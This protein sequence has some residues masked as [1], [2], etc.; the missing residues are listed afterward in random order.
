[1]VQRPRDGR[2]GAY[3]GSVDRPGDPPGPFSPR[4]PEASTRPV[5]VP[6]RLEN[7]FAGL[8]Q[9]WD[10]CRCDEPDP[11]QRVRFHTDAQD[12]T[13]QAWQRLLDLIDEVADDGREEFVPAVEMP[14]ELWRQI[15]TLPP[16]IAKLSAVKRLTLYG[17]NLIAIP[18]EIGEMTSL[19]DFRPYT[20]RRLHW[21]PYEITRCSSLRRSTASTRNIYG[22]FGWRM[23]FPELPAKVPSGSIPGACSVCQ[24]PLPSAGAIQ[25]WVSLPVAT[26]VLP[27]LVHACSD[28]CICSLP[29]SAEG[30]VL[31][32]HLGGPEL[33]QPEAIFGHA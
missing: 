30:Y 13:G 32:P 26:D 24:G 18:P 9:I 12:T 28:D 29:I 7:R 33:K 21:F 22:N 1:M 5:K 19:E 27:L 8:T 25:A 15:V 23:P 6:L 4:K 31:G 10:P 17:S 14:E 11:P 3:T 20:S 16:S 2:A